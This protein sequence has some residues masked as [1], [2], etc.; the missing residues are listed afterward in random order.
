MSVGRHE[1]LQIDPSF[2]RVEKGKQRYV[3]Q[4]E[5]FADCKGSPQPSRSSKSSIYVRLTPSGSLPSE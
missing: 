5:T 1:N 3:M 4:D 2:I